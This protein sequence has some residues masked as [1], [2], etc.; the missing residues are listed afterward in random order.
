MTQPV[1]Q[2][3][4]QASLAEATGGPC[5]VSASL[6]NIMISSHHHGS[7]T[8]SSDP[9]QLLIVESYNSQ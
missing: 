4:G 8:S 1:T 3:L 2:D 6:Y 9:L 7:L 5:C